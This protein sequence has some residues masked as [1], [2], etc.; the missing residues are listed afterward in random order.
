M[1]AP[2][3]DPLGAQRL[4]E[5]REAGFDYIEMSLAHVA[6]LGEEAFQSLSARIE[7]AGL[8]CEAC[9]N[10]FPASIRLTGPESDLPAALRYATAAMDRAKTLGAEVIVFGSAGARHLPEGFDYGRGCEQLVE[11]LRALAPLAERRG[12]SIATEALN[13]LECNIINRLSEAVDLAKAVNRSAVGVVIDS[14]HLEIEE[15]DL[16]II[17]SAGPLARHVHIALGR[18]RRFPVVWDRHLSAVFG[19]LV[20]AGYQGRCS[21]EAYTD[22]FVGDAG[23]SLKLLRQLRS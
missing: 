8:R 21:I 23:R 6:V 12:M 5:M 9:N 15:E 20:A 16:G 4:E 18:S 19:S 2:T 13:Q 11:L 7:G 1:I 3:S 17:G 14:Y 22:D 10:F